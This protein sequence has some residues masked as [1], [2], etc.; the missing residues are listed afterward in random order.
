M[1]GVQVGLGA[2]HEVPQVLQLDGVSSAVQLP[3]QQPFLVAAPAHVALSGKPASAGQAAAIP[4]H[5]SGRSQAPAALR[6]TVE[7]P[8]SVSTGQPASLPLQTS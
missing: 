2:T 8:E 7:L 6:Q 3:A 1:P 5:V 4:L